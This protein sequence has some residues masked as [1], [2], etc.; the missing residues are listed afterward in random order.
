[1]VFSSTIDR[2]D[3]TM[4]W[5]QFANLS[6]VSRKSFFQPMYEITVGYNKA[7]VDSCRI[8][9]SKF[10]KVIIL[11]DMKIWR[12]LTEI[13]WFML[14]P[15]IW[16][17]KLFTRCMNVNC[18]CVFCGIHIGLRNLTSSYFRQISST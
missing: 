1:M 18:D 8:K 11:K 15:I 13:W 16:I 2:H 4:M 3:Q 5:F 14:I 6:H 7:I 9:Q 17:R 12:L 10:S